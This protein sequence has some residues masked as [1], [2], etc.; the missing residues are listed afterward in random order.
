MDSSPSESSG[1]GFQKNICYDLHRMLLK[2]LV[3]AGCLFFGPSL[4]GAAVQKIGP[5]LYA[6]I[7]SNDASA[8]ATFHVSVQGILVGDTVLIDEKGR[9]LREDSPKFTSGHVSWYS[10]HTYLSTLTG[11]I[12][13]CES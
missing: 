10:N 6:Y 2:I 7:S 4:A 5:D 11:A 13:T 12:C 3:L 9:S 8:N 1:S